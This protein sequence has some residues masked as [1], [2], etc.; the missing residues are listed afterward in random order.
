MYIQQRL[1][2][3]ARGLSQDQAVKLIAELGQVLHD[4]EEVSM[5]Y[6]CIAPYWS[7]TGDPLIEGQKTYEE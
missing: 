6:D 1:E 3:W 5:P 2:E 7:N 4:S